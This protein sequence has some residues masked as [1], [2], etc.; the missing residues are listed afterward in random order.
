MPR[1]DKQ[2]NRAKK[3]A[4]AEA[5]RILQD[6]IDRKTSKAPTLDEV[7]AADF[8]YGGI[9]KMNDLNVHYRITIPQLGRVIH[10]HTEHGGKVLTKA[11][12]KPKIRETGLE[13]P[14]IREAA[15]TGKLTRHDFDK[16][17]VKVETTYLDN[18][19]NEAVRQKLINGNYA[20]ALIDGAF[21]L[22]EYELNFYSVHREG[23]FWGGYP[24]RAKHKQIVQKII[25]LS[26]EILF[27]LPG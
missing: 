3:E 27:K 10:C 1:F 24:D 4:E 15:K 23:N 6:K 17:L 19:L 2:E 16:S 7:L 22:G 11:H 9:F 26:D 20:Q 5:E 8:K 18:N 12:M 13:E 25:D 14:V 21:K